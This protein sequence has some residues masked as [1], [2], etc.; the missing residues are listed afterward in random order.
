MQ[1]F[2]LHHRDQNLLFSGDYRTLRECVEDALRDGVNLDGI[3][4]SRSDLS[5]INLD[6]VRIAGAN[7]AHV[8]L[9][10]AN[11]SE[12]S[13]QDCDFTG[14]ALFNACFCHSDLSG[15]NFSDA[16]CGGTD[17]AGTRLTRCIF[18]GRPALGMNFSDSSD[19]QAARYRTP[20]KDCPMTMP[21]LIVSGLPL[22]VALFDHDVL[23]G[24][25]LYNCAHLIWKRENP[26]LI[27]DHL[28]HHMFKT[29]AILQTL[30]NTYSPFGC[31]A[32][33][34]STER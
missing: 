14:A 29:V 2:Q 22:P 21:P 11:V 7:F 34:K 18:S 9:T 12:A 23:V 25:S 27:G 32:T 30:R 16:L 3:D 15:S 10:G 31:I 5:E 20:W 6:G 19:M 13:L 4:L 28:S 26:D 33:Q 17:L 1:T 24:A 8:N